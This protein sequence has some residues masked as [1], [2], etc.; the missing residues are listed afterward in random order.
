[1]L[2]AR[3]AKAKIRS[4]RSIDQ[5]CRAMK[6]VASIRLRRAENRLESARPYQRALAGLVARVAAAAEAQLFL[7]PPEAGQTALVLITS[8]RGLCGG[9]NANAIR[10]ALMVGGPK[11][12]GVVAVGRR[13]QVQMARRGYE[14]VERL[15][16]LGGEPE[17]QALRWLADRIG[18]LYAEGRFG[19][20]VVVFSRF[21]GGT[22]YEV[23]ADT[24]LP[25]RLRSGQAL[26]PGEMEEP[27]IILEPPLAALLPG[28]LR[29]Y[30][31]SQ[32]ANMVLESS[33]SE[34]AARVAAMA[35]A[36]DN[37]EEM[38]RDLTLAYNKAR[39]AGITKELTEI[40]AASEATA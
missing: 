18:D 15:V 16:P 29:R 35:A 19:E 11:E 21:L 2:T 28:L 31:R 4:V 40:V 1:M 13:G 14:I 25:L 26:A 27:D 23:R 38:M 32:L 12:V 39:Q 36:T 3:D 37:A 20:V 9:Y 17:M 34:H 5:I 6:T 33:A 10:R 8:D 22:R 30:V 7:Q 24:L